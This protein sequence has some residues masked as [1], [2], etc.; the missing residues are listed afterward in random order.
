MK[1]SASFG[2]ATWGL[3]AS[4]ALPALAAPSLESLG[5][6]LSNLK[7]VG[8]DR[9]HDRVH[10]D[11]YEGHD[12]HEGKEEGRPDHGHN[13][14]SVAAAC[15][16]ETGLRSLQGSTA[17]RLEFVNTS[18]REVRVY[19]LDYKGQRVFYRAIPAGGKYLQ[20]TFKTHPWVMTDQND[21][22]IDLLVSQQPY[23]SYRIR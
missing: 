22:C 5:Q 2:F 23:Q 20:P 14:H 18:S 13:D 12:R 7:Q 4:L 3:L 15:R 10:R 11:R 21:R 17:T 1:V 19:W 16:Q 8:Q 6:Q 9:M